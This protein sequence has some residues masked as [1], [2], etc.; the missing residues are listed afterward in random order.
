MI[1]DPY[2]W[3]SSKIIAIEPVATDTVAVHLERPA[4][5]V[6][7]AGQYSV[8]RTTLPNGEQRIRQYSFSSSPL[9]ENQLEMLIQR[10]P[11][12]EVSGWFCDDA[13]VG[14]EIELS[15]ALGGFVLN[16][17][18]RPTI[19]IAGKVGVAPFLSML[20]DGSHPSLSLLYSIRTKDQVC[21]REEL[22]LY[23]TAVLETG[24]N[25]HI[26][27]DLLQPFTAKKPV[28]Y[29]CGSKQ[30]VD[31]MTEILTSIGVPMIDIYRELFT[32]Q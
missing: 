21:Y 10:E 6:F 2:H 18:E 12:G 25:G 13:I 11:S 14:S 16:N 9:A 20:R 8:V 27:A 5:Y 26:N 3:T 29:I 7:K 19:L 1:I 31:A 28:F 24:K 15:Q 30:F 23:N 4:G 22:H 17:L 32:L